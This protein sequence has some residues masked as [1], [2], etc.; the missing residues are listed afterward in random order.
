MPTVSLILL[1][2]DP[3]VPGFWGSALQI[4]GIVVIVLTLFELLSNLFP[5]LSRLK[6]NLFKFL[7]NHVKYKK[8]EKKAIALDIEGA[9][10]ETVVELQNE[11][12]Y[13]WVK[14]A[15]IQWVKEQ[16]SSD[17]KEG[18]I[19]LRIR[20]QE[21]QDFNLVNGIYTFFSNSMFPETR[22]IIP[23]STQMAVS[24]QISRRTIEEK[25]PFVIQ[26]FEDEIIEREVKSNPAILTYLEDFKQLDRKGFFTGSF[27]REIDYT[28]KK[29][30]FLP[31]R[32]NFD[33]EIGFIID[34]IKKFIES[35]PEAPNHLW[36][37]RSGTSSYRFL[38]VKNPF[39]YKHK[40]YVNRAQMSLDD[41]IEHL[42]IMGSGKEKE[43]VLKVI[44]EVKK[45]PRYKLAEVYTLHRDFRGKR[46]G[47]GALFLANSTDKK[48]T[49]VQNHTQS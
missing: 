9:I 1:Q 30:R 34:H 7:S 19:I 28:A 23:A 6:K 43:F 2:S 45:I 37:R 13:G 27:L 32:K 41:G 26:L 20:P 38:L 8:I 36:S 29:I 14:K 15:S 31:E 39:K 35:L 47:I 22:E 18:E 48:N 25:R 40:I 16:K 44:E 11:L 33:E 46:N 49:N 5:K 24:L 12:P 42:F 3:V 21:K 10:N 4:V 17:L